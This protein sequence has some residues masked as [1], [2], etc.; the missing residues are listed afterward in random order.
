MSTETDHA[1]HLDAQRATVAHFERKL[2]RAQQAVDQAV[3]QRERVT[4]QLA[5]ERERLARLVV[6]AEGEE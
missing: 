6:E 1:T 4:R 5:V 3:A 2:R